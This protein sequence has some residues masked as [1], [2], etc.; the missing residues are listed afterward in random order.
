M[1]FKEVCEKALHIVYYD[2]NQWVD[3]LGREVNYKW[4][5]IITWYQDRWC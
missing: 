5:R 4:E 1:T 3:E 2:Q